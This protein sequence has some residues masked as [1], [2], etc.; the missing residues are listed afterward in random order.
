MNARLFCKTG[1]LAGTGFTIENEA[2]IGKDPSVQVVVNQAVI[3]RNHAKISF[4][5][6]QNC[7]FLED[8]KSSNGTKLDGMTVRDKERLGNLHVITL[9]DVHDF[10]FQVLKEGQIPQT[11]ARPVPQA[12]AF[13][14]TTMDSDMPAVPAAIAPQ[15]QAF[16]GTKMDT[17]MPAL[18]PGL[19]VGGEMKMPKTMMDMDVPNLPPSLE[20][21]GQMSTPRTMADTDFPQLPS[22]MKPGAPG[23]RTMAETDFPQLPAGMKPGA[24]GSK[25]VHQADAFVVPKLQ[26]Q[27]PPPPQPK[28]QPP[29]APAPPA[30]TAPPP[31]RQ[32]DEYAPTVSVESVNLVYAIQA[33]KLQKAF[34]LKEGENI[35][36]RGQTSE[37]FIDHS[38]VSRKH[39]TIKVQSGKVTVKDL[40]SSN[41]TFVDGKQIDSEVEITPYSQIKFGTVEVK[42]IPQ[43]TPKR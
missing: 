37:V 25:T 13:P 4:D 19:G 5:E 32:T 11:V 16:S 6:S 22:G 21:G 2:V 8:L 12:S 38:T 40:G 14:K 43:Q 7:Y 35:V 20:K 39:A 17:D 36:G 33:E 3:S 23:S 29:A 27:A 42:L 41:H 1:T 18:P 26:P 15:P 30:A 34:Q 31:S 10:I 24:P 9:A 28:P